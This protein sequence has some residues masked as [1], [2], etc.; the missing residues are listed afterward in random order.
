[1]ADLR[2]EV[3]VN[4]LTK[5]FYPDSSFLKYPKDFSPLVENH[6]INM[7]EAGVDPAVLINNTTYPISVTQRTD[8]PLRIE[9]HKFET[10]NTLVRSPEVVEYSYDKLE[11]VIMGHRNVLRA[12]TAE[13]AAHS[14]APAGDTAFTPIVTTS[15]AVI[16]GRNRLAV[17]DILLLKE[18]YDSVDIPYEN[19]YL[20]LHPSHLSDLVLIDLKSFKDI[21][22][23]KN[24]LPQRLAGFNILQF[25]KP[26]NYV[27]STL[28]KK[29]FGAASVVGDT[30]CSFSFHSEEVMKADGN[31]KMYQVK[32]DPK[33]R[34]TIVGF[35]KR[36]IAVPIRNKGQGAIVSTLVDE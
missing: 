14:Y 9:F 23:I 3:W 21:A 16:G 35:E 19:R 7:T 30:F 13:M 12:R 28:T 5:N 15:G 33:E 10:E 31:V 17:E 4:Q 27:F 29:A 22:D 34:A 18:R 24:G 20:V 36:F 32:D 11:S 1:M 6:A 8:T 2:T 26:A 25:S